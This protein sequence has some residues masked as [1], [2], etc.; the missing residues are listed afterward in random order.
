MDDAWTEQQ[1]AQYTRIKEGLRKAGLSEHE[2]AANARRTI[3]E[4]RIRPGGRGRAI[5]QEPTKDQL[6]REAMRYDITG[7]S[8]MDKEQ[9]EH[10]VRENRRSRGE[11]DEDDEDGD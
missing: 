4:A 11:D 5:S 1:L 2:A 9:L 7:R 3:E 8:K 10:A 6:Y